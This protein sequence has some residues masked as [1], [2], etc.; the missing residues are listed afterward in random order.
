MS[1]FDDPPKFA[2]PATLLTAALRDH[3]L[4]TAMAQLLTVG[5]GIVA[6][7]A[8]ENLGRLKRTTAHAANGRDR[9]DERQQ[10]L[11]VVCIRTRR[12][13]A[14]RHAVGVY[15]DV[16]PRTGSRTIRGVRT[17]FSAAPT[18]RTDE[19]S[20]AAREKSSWSVSRSF[21][22]TSSCRRSHTPASCQSRA[23]AVNKL[24]LSR[25]PTASA[26][27]SSVFLSSSRTGCR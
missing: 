7:I 21:A 22:S 24:R 8:I 27:G 14:D 12:D 11:E 5:I 9:I 16:V 18:A 15:E 26:S 1:S 10:L 25:T 19:E 4:D 3:R 17:S 2:Q 6:A 23:V 13:R 20:T